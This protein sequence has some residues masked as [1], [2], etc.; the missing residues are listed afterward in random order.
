MREIWLQVLD[1]K[2]KKIW[3]PGFFGGGGGG[4]GM[5]WLNMTT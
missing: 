1:R 4:T 3:E 5:Y 2:V